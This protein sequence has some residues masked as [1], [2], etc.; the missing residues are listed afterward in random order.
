MVSSAEQEYTRR[1]VEGYDIDELWAKGIPANYFALPPAVKNKL[2][3]LV[4]EEKKKAFGEENMG[5]A[6]G[7]GAAFIN[8]EA[9]GYPDNILASRRDVRV[10]KWT[11]QPS[12]P[13]PPPPQVV[14]PARPVVSPPPK[15]EQP[16]VIPPQI[17]T[18]MDHEDQQSMTI[19]ENT[20]HDD[21]WVEGMSGQGP[22]MM[23]TGKS[24]R[25][26]Y[27]GIVRPKW[28]TVVRP[29]TKNTRAHIVGN[30]PTG[31]LDNHYYAKD[32]IGSHSFPA[33][34]SPHASTGQRGSEA[35]VGSIRALQPGP[36]HWLFGQ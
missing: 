7:R 29:Y 1:Y 34:L 22:P 25:G 3:G 33:F 8:F 16:A 27:T 5:G 2:V 24:R 17:D 13:P 11:A 9:R 35:V 23:G 32:L 20:E 19:E 12:A 21:H 30:R 6:S 28:P 14:Q 4:W 15:E 31:I 36:H 26:R 10:G 18:E